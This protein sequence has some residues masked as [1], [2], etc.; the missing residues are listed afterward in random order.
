LVTINILNQYEI[1]YKIKKVTNYLFSKNISMHKWL[2][3]FQKYLKNNI[4]VKYFFIKYV[5]GFLY[6]WVKCEIWYT[7][8]FL[9]E[10]KEV[11]S[12]PRKSY[13]VKTNIISVIQML[14]QHDLIKSDNFFKYEIWH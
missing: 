8:S 12:A 10:K 4:W 2:I 6:K 7:E 9:K 13:W 5:N 14:T 3:I 11:S 1:R